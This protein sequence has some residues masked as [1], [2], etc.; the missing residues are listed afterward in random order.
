MYL[1]KSTSHE[2]CLISTMHVP[3]ESMQQFLTSQPRKE[4]GE[5]LLFQA[6]GGPHSSHGRLAVTPPG[7]PVPPC[8]ALVFSPCRRVARNSSPPALLKAVAMSGMIGGNRRNG[9]FDSYSRI[10]NRFNWVRNHSGTLK[11][12]VV[13]KIKNITLPR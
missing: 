11:Y 10:V 3:D 12:Y 13:P 5:S 7:Q 2:G 1:N 8:S 9:K 6:S 4:G